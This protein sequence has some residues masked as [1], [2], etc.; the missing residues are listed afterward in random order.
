MVID[1]KSVFRIFPK[2]ISKKYH[3]IVIYMEVY[4]ICFSSYVLDGLI[5]GTKLYP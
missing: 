3:D 5:Q 2:N 1:T 4:Y